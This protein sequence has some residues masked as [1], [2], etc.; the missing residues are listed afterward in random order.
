MTTV[1]DIR[2]F[3]N[4]G[5]KN[6]ATH[7]IVVCDTFGYEDYPVFVSSN[8][9]VREVHERYNNKEMQRV[10]EVYN[11]SMNIEEQLKEKRC[12]NF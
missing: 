3:L 6:K 9:N 7:V 12:F 10:V 8:E 5:I 11:L 4:R 1:D 2:K